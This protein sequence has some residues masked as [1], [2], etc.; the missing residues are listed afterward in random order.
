MEKKVEYLVY[1]EEGFENYY[2]YKPVCIATD[3]IEA[4]KK[5]DELQK[6][7]D[8]LTN[9]RAETLSAFRK[10]FD[11]L[12]KEN[13]LLGILKLT[14]QNRLKYYKKHAKLVNDFC[15]SNNISLEELYDI[16]KKEY[17]FVELEVI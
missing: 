3:I 9:K 12:E 14:E 1:Y 7:E 2:A 10:F 17:N 15:K 13:T 11:K 8:K 6:V 16:D 4:K 5:V